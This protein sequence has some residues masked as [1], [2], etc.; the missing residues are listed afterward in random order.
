[1]ADFRGSQTRFL[2]ATTVDLLTTGV[3]VPNVRN[4]VFFKYVGS[5]I[6]F[7]QMVGRGTRIDPAT[8]KLMFRVYDYTNATRLFGERFVARLGRETAEPAATGGGESPRTI[9]VEGIDVRITDAG[10]LIPVRGDAGRDIL[11]TVEEYEQR[12]AARLVEDA[13]TLE[14]FRDCWVQPDERRSLL[15]DLHEAGYSPTLI[16]HL[17]QMNDYDLYDVLAELGYGVAPRTRS[18]RAARFLLAQRAWLDGLPA[19]GAAAIRAIAQQF[20]RAGTDELENPAI[21]GLPAVVRAGGLEA[22]KQ[23]GVPREV[24]RETKER[25]F[26]A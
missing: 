25:M 24:L 3:D 7:Y 12:L 4:V 9:R 10:R 18:E 15:L 1:M 6:A 22:L 14:T 16:Q 23:V 13:P 2:I 19:A 21:F 17:E 20:E 5:P 26:A 8:G 11:I